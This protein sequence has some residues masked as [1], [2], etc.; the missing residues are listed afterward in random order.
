MVEA[1]YSTKSLVI[2]PDFTA[3]GR[4][5]LRQPSGSGVAKRGLGPAAARML[6]EVGFFVGGA[7]RVNPRVPSSVQD[8]LEK[9]DPAVGPPR[10]LFRLPGTAPVFENMATVVW[11]HAGKDFDPSVPND[12]TDSTRYPISFF[13]PAARLAS[14]RRGG[15]VGLHFTNRM[16]S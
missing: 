5:Y 3:W 10:M 12:R 14:N 8:V 4:S 2:I 9:L 6:Q 1:G 15:G 11:N 7:G 16:A 13:D